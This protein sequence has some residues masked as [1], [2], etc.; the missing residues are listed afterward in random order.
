[1][2]NGRL[3]FPNIT[4]FQNYY[5]EL[6]NKDENK[7]AD[8]LEDKFYSKDFYS[9]KPIVNK[10]TEKTEIARHLA[11]IKT[12]KHGLQQKLTSKNDDLLENFDDLEDI[13]GEDVFTS[14]LNQDAEIQVGEKIYKYT[15]TGL[16]IAKENEIDGLNSYLNKKQISNNLL[17]ETPES[18]KLTYIAN[19][20]PCGGACNQ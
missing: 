18:I 6:R 11:K 3:Y 20:N 17:M 12:N 9:L 7:V 14:F 19:Y 8:I 15:D 16:F 2:L 1:V 4:I 10:R 13:F 5:K